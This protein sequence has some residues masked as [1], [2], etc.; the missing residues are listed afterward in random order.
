MQAGTHLDQ[1]LHIQHVIAVPAGKGLEPLE[2]RT[3]LGDN[4]RCVKYRLHTK[5]VRW[6]RIMAGAGGS[7]V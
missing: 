7:G 1:H 6:W 5:S 3:L 4:N 2:S